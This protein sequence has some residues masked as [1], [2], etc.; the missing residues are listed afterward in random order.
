MHAV[1]ALE[2]ARQDKFAVG[3]G[4]NVSGG[5]FVEVLLTCSLLS[6]EPIAI[7]LWMFGVIG[8]ARCDLSFTIRDLLLWHD[9]FCAEVDI[10]L[11]V[12]VVVPITLARN[13]IEVNDI[14]NNNDVSE[15]PENTGV[16]LK[17]DVV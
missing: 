2:V 12:T 3:L 8:K 5:L 4:E 6:V 10:E 13:A 17:S 15:S 7:L 9:A 16:V 11:L 1:E 14:G